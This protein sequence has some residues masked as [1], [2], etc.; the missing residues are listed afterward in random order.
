MPK[1]K[2]PEEIEFN[3]ATRAFRK[4]PSASNFVR[5]RSAMYA[6]QY[7]IKNVDLKPRKES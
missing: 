6:Y 5:L 4:N 7:V 1:S 2:T 3:A